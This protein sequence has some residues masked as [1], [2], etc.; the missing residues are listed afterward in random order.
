MG[1]PCGSR[2][3]AAEKNQWYIRAAAG[4]IWGRDADFSDKDCKSTSPPALFGCGPGS[5][6]KSLGTDGDFGQYLVLEF[7]GGRHLKP[8]LRTEL[9]FHFR[10][11]MKYSGSANFL[12]V[13]GPQPVST[14]ARSMGLMTNVFVELAPLLDLSASRWHPYLGAGAGL[15][16]NKLDKVTYRFPE[17]QNHHLSITPSGRRWDAAYQITAGLGILFTQKWI[18]D[19]S[20]RYE[21]LGSVETDRGGMY[22]D[23]I[24]GSIDIARTEADL[25][26]FGTLIGLRY[27]Y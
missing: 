23:H 2:G 13:S 25:K 4:A 15:S 3:H 24:N 16:H 27:N 7:A 18:L 10:P 11:N 8:W 26:G 22:M 17:A 6:G 21:D 14:T 1:L 9:A 12:N 19:I 20:V 5:D